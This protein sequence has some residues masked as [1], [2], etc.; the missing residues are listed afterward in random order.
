M[1]LDAQRYH[2]ESAHDFLSRF[3]LVKTFIVFVLCFFLAFVLTP[4]SAFAD[5]NIRY[6]AHD[7]R[8]S[9]DLATLRAAFEIMRDEGTYDCQ[10]PLSWYYQGAIHWLPTAD[11]DISGIQS[12]NPK[13]DYYSGFGT[14][15]NTPE[16]KL[17][18]AWD[19]CTHTSAGNEENHFLAWH[20]LYVYH[21]EKVVRYLTGDEDFRM[22]YWGYISL[23]DESSPDDNLLKLPS[24]FLAP[25][26]SL[27]EEARDTELLEGESIRDRFVQLYFVDAV[28]NLRSEDSYVGF[29]GTIDGAPHGLMHDYLG[30]GYT[31]ELNPKLE[32]G[33]GPQNV[34]NRNIF[35]T[36]YNRVTTDDGN[37]Q[38]GLMTNVPSAGFDPIFWTHHG[39]IDRLWSQW[40]Q[41]ENGEAVT[42]DDLAAPW[43]YEFY[44]PEI[45]GW[46]V[47]DIDEAIDK[48]Y[49]MDYVY[50]GYNSN[51]TVSPNLPSEAIRK[52]KRKVSRIQL[53]SNEN[54]VVLD[55]S[56]V[57]TQ[58]IGLNAEFGRR[59]PLLMSLTE[60]V[61]N[62]EQSNYILEVDVTYTGRPRGVY[63]LYLN[64]P[65]D[66]TRQDAM[67][68]IE[69]YF[70]GGLSFFVNESN[71]P[72]TKT[73]RFGITD[74]LLRQI[75][76]DES[77]N[78]DNI[79]VSIRKQGG[80][81]DAP[82]TIE[83]LAV[84]IEE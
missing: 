54:S 79:S 83:R 38:Y 43:A 64:L 19:N 66:D 71:L 20:R 13:C 68:D 4:S 24:D 39:N 45:N 10:N 7:S 40:T 62:L 32:S 17:L 29:N 16:D 12:G 76:M 84:H 37:P 15:S 74:E 18:R 42:A 1:I 8:A 30:G 5:G 47:Y 11:K 78:L 49:S 82:L 70:I 65:E 53:G 14:T 50:M 6:E 21:L 56:Q 34:D 58:P 44:D 35:N 23:D 57:L 25:D 36:I 81:S 59:L 73:F 69:T 22:P 46:K 52:Q 33:D 55:G 31:G 75:Q 63:E 61:D 27:Y 3:Q 77:S 80:A 60:D 67:A 2:N 9:S 51:E 48:M 26:S 28:E 72:R 41:S